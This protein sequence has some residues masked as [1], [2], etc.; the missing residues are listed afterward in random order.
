MDLFK[1]TLIVFLIIQFVLSLSVAI[2]NGLMMVAFVKKRTLQTPSN[3]VLGCLCCSDLLIGILTLPI[4]GIY[5]SLAL[6]NS[7]WDSKHLMI[8]IAEAFL[9]FTGLSSLFMMLVT[10]DRFTA[11]CHPYKYIQYAV[12]KR[13][14]VTSVGICS[15][16]VF[17]FGVAYAIDKLYQ[18]HSVAIIIITVFSA[19]SFIL[20][21]CN[22]KI[23][24]VIRRHRREIVSVERQINRHNNRFSRETKRYHSI[25]L[26][27]I[28]YF[29]C[30]APHIALFLFIL[31]QKLRFTV[32]LYVLAK[33]SD[34]LL[35]LN[36]MCNPLVYCLSISSLRNAVK[37][38]FCRKIPVVEEVL[39]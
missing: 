29:F 36:S 21:C 32:S 12:A 31:M 27:V 28:L 6:N 37:E 7:F 3:G 22:L 1:T 13:Y 20:I 15:C 34:I 14:I 2:L 18:V 39:E 4:W 38:I 16:Y 25:V 11:I 24:K 19:T 8:S 35:L 30:K 23:I 9:V 33:V 5:V 10:L 17:I 26:L